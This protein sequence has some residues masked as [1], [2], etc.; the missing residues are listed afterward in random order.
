VKPEYDFDKEV[1]L[2]D[3][4]FKVAAGVT[5][6][7]GSHAHRLVLDEVL[8]ARVL[9]LKDTEAYVTKAEIRYLVTAIRLLRKVVNL[10]N[11]IGKDTK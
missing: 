10:R 7:K 6:F 4:S 3:D 9:E 1:K 5:K 2:I 8:R 11:D